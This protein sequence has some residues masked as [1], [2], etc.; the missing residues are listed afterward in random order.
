MGVEPLLIDTS[1]SPFFSQPAEFAQLL[2]RAVDTTPIGPLTP[3][4]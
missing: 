4:D 2:V 1:H 3:G